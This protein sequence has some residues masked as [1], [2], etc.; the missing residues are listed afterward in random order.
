M[1]ASHAFR[2]R[3]SVYSRNAAVDSAFVCLLYK[4]RVAFNYGVLYIV[5]FFTFTALSQY[6]FY[7]LSAHLAMYI[8]NLYLY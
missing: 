7:L 1:L 6:C 2:P 4:G 8:V 3:T 5:T